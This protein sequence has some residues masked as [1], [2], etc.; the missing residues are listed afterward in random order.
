[1]ASEKAPAFPFYPRDFVGD[2]DVAASSLEEVGFYT[3]LL[4]Y[5]WLKD[6]LPNDHAKLARALHV[7]PQKFARLWAVVGEKFPKAPDERL[8]NP[9]QEEVREEQRAHRAERSES[10]RRGNDRRWKDTRSAIAQSSLSDES[11]NAEGSPSSSSASASSVQPPK[12]Q[13]AVPRAHTTTDTGAAARVF[14]QQL[15]PA[16]YRQWRHGAFYRAREARVFPAVLQLVTD[17]PDSA[18]LAA[19]VQ[20]WLRTDLKFAVDGD[21]GIEQ[22]ICR[23]A[24]CDALLREAGHHPGRLPT[25]A[26]IGVVAHVEGKTPL[27]GVGKTAGN[28]AA[29][30]TVLNRERGTDGVDRQRE[31]P[32]LQAV[33]SPR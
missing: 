12:E 25:D 7:T 9:R 33:G 3:V 4:C 15:Y 21:R 14:I 26:E 24:W 8:R 17:F 18:W 11:A 20:C 16:L 22:F 27:M 2:L 28:L 32:V 5:A 10:G 23:A 31:R 6:G 30:E 29:L 13:V 1:M 19:M